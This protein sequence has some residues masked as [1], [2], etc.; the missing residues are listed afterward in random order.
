MSLQ[1]TSSIIQTAITCL[2]GQNQ[3]IYND[4]I[5]SSTKY[6]ILPDSQSS[7]KKTEQNKSRGFVLEENNG[8]GGQLKFR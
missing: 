4:T 7:S 8:S 3:K 1:V 5:F 6:S 2:R